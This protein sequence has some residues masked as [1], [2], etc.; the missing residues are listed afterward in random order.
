MRSSRSQK[1]SMLASSRGASTS[2]RTQIGA[3]LVRNK[4][5]ISATAVSACSPP[6]RRVSD[7]GFLPGLE[8]VVRIDQLQMR[9]PAVEQRGEEAAEMLVHRLER[10]EQALP[11]FAVVR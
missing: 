1:R 5:K 4:A 2:S 11:A 6:D 8:R 10:G 9:L 3:G 7:W